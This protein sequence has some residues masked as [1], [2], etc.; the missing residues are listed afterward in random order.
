MHYQ[1]L[2]APGFLV[3]KGIYMSQFWTPVGY[4]WKSGNDLPQMT[5]EISSAVRKAWV[6]AGIQNVYSEK[7]P[8][9]S[10]QQKTSKSAEDS[11]N[12]FTKRHTIH[13]IDAPGVELNTWN[14]KR[15]TPT[16]SPI[17]HN[18]KAGATCV[19]MCAGG[20]ETTT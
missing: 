20:R 1:K 11:N 18:L 17:I 7:D 6:P 10:I 12:N 9:N 14:S 4:L 15:L 19:C 8:A 16:L 13:N 5:L 2:S 3:F